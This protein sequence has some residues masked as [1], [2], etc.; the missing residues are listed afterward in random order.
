M[1][2]DQSPLGASVG[3]FSRKSGGV[4]SSFKAAGRYTTNT[5]GVGGATAA[6]MFEE[7]CCKCR[8]TIKHT[9]SYLQFHKQPWCVQS[10]H[11]VAIILFSRN[12]GTTFVLPE[13]AVWHQKLNYHSFQQIFV[14]NLASS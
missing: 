5:L 8:F 6:T 10:I 1:T 7:K 14:N 12:S 3:S 13:T 9:S 11:F 2:L 4:R